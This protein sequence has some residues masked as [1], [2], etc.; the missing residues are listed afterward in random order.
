MP[1]Q[2][3]V[4]LGE[5]IQATCRIPTS[6]AASEKPAPAAQPDLSS[7]TSMLQARWKGAAGAGPSKPEEIRAGQVRSFRIT[8]LEPAAKKIELDL[9]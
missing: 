8:K 9:V 1:G 3:R 5:G 7:L 4:E 6:K 2:A